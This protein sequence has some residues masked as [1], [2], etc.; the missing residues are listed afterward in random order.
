MK[1]T[2][3]T[4]ERVEELREWVEDA[5]ETIRL[6]QP[7]DRG[8]ADDLLAILDDYAGRLESPGP[9]ARCPECRG[10]GVNNDAKQ[11]WDIPDAPA[12]ECSFCF[13][14]GEVNAVPSPGPIDAGEL[15]KKIEAA[16]K[17]NLDEFM[18]PEYSYWSFGIDDFINLLRSLGVSVESGE[19][20]GR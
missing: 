6:R 20:G 1:D 11:A 12:P 18:K 14:T 17:L 9:T 19:E 8:K 5:Y 3:I 13:G 10:T 15:E 16:A 2:T 7:S 4:Q